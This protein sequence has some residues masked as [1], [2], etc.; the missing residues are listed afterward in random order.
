MKQIQRIIEEILGSHVR[1]DLCC[2]DKTYKQR[3]VWPFSTG[4]CPAPPTPCACADL[5]GA[6]KQ[7]R[8][9]GSMSHPPHP[10]HL[11]FSLVLLCVR[12]EMP[13]GKQSEAVTGGAVG[14]LLWQLPW[15]ELG[16]TLV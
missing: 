11:E 15:N 4:S 7:G 3:V 12:G 6:D 10:L 13:S 16:K 1:A 14:V 8:F 2:C 9:Q 5:G